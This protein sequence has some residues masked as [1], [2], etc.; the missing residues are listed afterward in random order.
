MSSNKK[1]AKLSRID[2]LTNLLN[3]RA[4]MQRSEAL[5]SLSIRQSLDFAVIMLDLDDFKK[6]NDAFGHQKGDDVIVMQ[7]D[8]MREIF[9]RQTDVLGRYGGEEFMVVVSGLTRQQVYSKCE[10][11][12][13]LWQSRS[14]AHADT[15]THRWVTCSI[16]IACMEK[17]KSTSLEALIQTADKA[18]YEAKSAGKNTI[19][20]ESYANP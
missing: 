15:A 10:Q 20:L 7:A 19:K 5:L 6:Y 12:S 4:L 1:L 14:I 2:S 17:G 18:L 16:G 9:K 8:L 3:R 13:M 11:M